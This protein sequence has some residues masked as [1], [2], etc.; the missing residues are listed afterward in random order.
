VQ[1]PDVL[2]PRALV[3]ALAVCLAGCGAATSPPPTLSRSSPTT[4]LLVASLGPGGAPLHGSAVPVWHVGDQWAFRWQSADGHGD[5][6]WTVDRFENLD[7]VVHYVV[8][9]G[10]REIY[11]RATD[12]ATSL[13]TLSGRVERR[14]LP[15]RVGFSWPLSTGAMWRQRYLEEGEGLSPAERAIDWAVEGEETVHVQ[16][17]AFRALRIAARF[18]PTPDLVYEMWYAPA[19]KQWVRLKEYFPAGVRSRELTDFALR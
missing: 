19:V 4:T 6:T 16:G 11:F 14:N 10:P 15:P 7:G 9:S 8:R 1:Y 17:G 3:I 12:L 2:S 5:Y 13:E 18:H